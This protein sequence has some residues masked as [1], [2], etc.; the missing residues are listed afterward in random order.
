[1]LQ[2]GQQSASSSFIFSTMQSRQNVWRHRATAVASLRSPRQSGHVMHAA[3]ASRRTRAN[4]LA[5][6]IP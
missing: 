4:R 1:M 3:S 5:A 2:T 6:L